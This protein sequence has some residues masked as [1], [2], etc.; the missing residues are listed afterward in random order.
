MTLTTIL[1]YGQTIKNYTGSYDEGTATYQYYENENYERIL[2]GNFTYKVYDYIITGQFKNNLR[3]GQWKAITTNKNNTNKQLTTEVVTATYVEGNL[4][5]ICSY[6]ETDVISKKIL[7][8]STAHFKGN[9]VVGEYSYTLNKGEDNISVIF[10]LN[11]DGFADSTLIIKYNYQRRQFEHIQ[12]YKNGFL[13]WELHRDMT[14]GRI[15]KKTD[16]KTFIDE[17]YSA[18]DPKTKISIIPYVEFPSQEQPIYLSRLNESSPNSSYLGTPTSNGNFSYQNAPFTFVRS[19]FENDY[20]SFWDLY[21][22][23][24]FWKNGNCDYCGN[25]VNPLYYFKKG[26]NIVSYSP[27]KELVLDDSSYN[28]YTN[29]KVISDNKK[30][31]QQLLDSLKSAVLSSIDWVNV[32]DSSKLLSTFSISAIPITNSQYIGFKDYEQYLVEKYSDEYFEEFGDSKRKNK[33]LEEAIEP[34]KTKRIVTTYNDSFD[35]NPYGNTDNVILIAKWLGL[36][37]ASN[38]QIRLATEGGYIKPKLPQFDYV[39]YWFTK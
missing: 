9:M 14:D 25:S 20:N 7:S 18:Y 27:V 24:N 34:I 38:E 16:K 11:Q 37:I 5:G 22:G 12:K 1:T 31:R 29:Q 26:A 13:Y 33:Q 23:I 10:N 4:E 21:K 3:T 15:I 39:V 19:G 8:K 32:N 2:N 35:N 30:H 6:S 17:F 36:T 28:N